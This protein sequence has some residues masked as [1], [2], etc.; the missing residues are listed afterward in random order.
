MT[1]SMTPSRPYLVQALNEWILD[2]NCTPYVLVDA[3]LP[4]V[5]VPQD[6]VQDGH[7]TLNIAPRAV[8]QLQLDDELF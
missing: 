8:A 4:G 2:N 6:Y 3:S 7:I 1:D 5:Q